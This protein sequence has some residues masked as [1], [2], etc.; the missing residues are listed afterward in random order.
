MRPARLVWDLDNTIIGFNRRGELI[1]NRPLVAKIR[2]LKAEGHTT[3]LWTFGNR[4]WWRAVR[5]TFPELL[6]LF[7]E[8]YSRDELRGHKTALPGY[9][10]LYVKDIRLINGDALIDNDPSHYIWAKRRRL[11]ERYVLAPQFGLTPV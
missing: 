9:G 6:G 8:I 2:Q 10:P 11:K 3:I 1:L 4:N 7:D 5:R